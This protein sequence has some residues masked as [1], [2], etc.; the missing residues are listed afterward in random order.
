MLWGI[1]QAIPRQWK[2]ALKQGQE[3][4]TMNRY[5]QLQ[6][7]KKVAKTCYKMLAFNESL[8]ES[9]FL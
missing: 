8:L 9:I 3:S 4:S 2:N 1:I 5:H 6:N 7:E